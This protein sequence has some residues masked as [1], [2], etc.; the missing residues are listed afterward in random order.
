MSTPL[1]SL[2]ELDETGSRGLEGSAC[3]LPW[4]FFV[5]RHGD[6]I[7]A[8]RNRCP[9]TGAPLDWMPDRFLDLDGELIQ[10][11]IHGALFQIEDG[12]CVRGPCLGRVLE[13]VGVVVREGMVWLENEAGRQ[14]QSDAGPVSA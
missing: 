12:M 13:P 4:D 10:C 11:A 1:C 9:H 7:R 2:D 5:V 6:H 8:Y 14:R 3:G